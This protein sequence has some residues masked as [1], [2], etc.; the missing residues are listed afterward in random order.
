[1]KDA[2]HIADPWMTLAWMTATA[3]I[4]PANLVQCACM[5]IEEIDCP[6]VIECYPVFPAELHVVN[7]LI[8]DACRTVSNAFEKSNEKT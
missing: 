3:E 5:V 2:G 1:M 4:V 6:A 7:L 8:S